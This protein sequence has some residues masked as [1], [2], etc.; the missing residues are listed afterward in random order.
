MNKSEVVLR[1]VKGVRVLK[2]CVL[3]GSEWDRTEEC[4][5]LMA[6]SASLYISWHRIRISS[7]SMGRFCVTF[8]IW[9]GYWIDWQE[10]LH[11]VWGGFTRKPANSLVLGQVPCR[12]LSDKMGFMIWTIW[13]P[14]MVF[15]FNLGSILVLETKFT[16]FSCKNI[17]T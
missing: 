9:D 2:S 15:R 12:S 14:V 10:W 3:E 5:L 6:P 16:Y 8:Y 13:N 11:A 17:L 4:M 7:V 1:Y